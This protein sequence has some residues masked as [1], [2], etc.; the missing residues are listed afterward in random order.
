MNPQKVNSPDI[1]P[2]G[3]TAGT[4]GSATQSPQITINAQGQATAAA[5]VTIAG[6]APGGA[7]GGDL[8]GTYPNPTVQGLKGEALPAEAGLQLIQRNQAN[9]AWVSLVQQVS[10]QFLNVGAGAITDEMMWVAR[11][12]CQIQS[13]EILARIAWTIAGVDT[14][15]V[16]LKKNGLNTVA[17]RT[18]TVLDAPGVIAISTLTMSAVAADTLFA[19]GDILTIDVAMTGGAV[20]AT[21]TY[22]FDYTPIGV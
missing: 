9:T 20:P 12:A 11:Q 18:F 4:Y 10:G 21:S 1:L 13:A 15:A 16:T 19:A 22:Q 14:I 8:G 5:N 7:A 2:T 3:V 17:Q 6:T